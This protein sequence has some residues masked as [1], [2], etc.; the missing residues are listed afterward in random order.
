MGEVTQ[1][2]RA[3]SVDRSAGAG[4][5]SRHPVDRRCE[6]CGGSLEGK[7]SHAL[8]CGADCRRA[9]WAIRRSAQAEKALETLPVGTQ[10]LADRRLRTVTGPCLTITLPADWPERST[11]FWTRMQEIRSRRGMARTER[12]R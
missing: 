9:A 11:R 3:G 1:A 4:A 2:T 8:Y 10:R 6:H 12:G 7:R 5:L